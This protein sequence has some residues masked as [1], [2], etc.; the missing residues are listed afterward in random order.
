[1]KFFGKDPFVKRQVCVVAKVLSIN[2]WVKFC[3]YNF[4]TL[5]FYIIKFIKNPGLQI[6]EVWKVIEVIDKNTG[7]L[8][9]SI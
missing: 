7:C 6:F 5:Y 2:R 9:L 3:E 1:M 4:L 8:F